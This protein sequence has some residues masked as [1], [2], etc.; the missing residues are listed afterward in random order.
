ML[1]PILAEFASAAMDVSDGLIGDCDKLALA[2]GCSASIDADAVP[3]PPGLTHC[4]EPVV[5]TMLTGGDDYEILAAIPVDDC[6][7]FVRAA[8]AVGVNVS[9]IGA[10]VGGTAPTQATLNGR[11]LNLRRRSYVHGRTGL[12][13]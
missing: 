9:R 13:K 8:Q 5:A 2:S 10:L 1:A 11:E 3:F 7:Q 4:M 6:D 12:D